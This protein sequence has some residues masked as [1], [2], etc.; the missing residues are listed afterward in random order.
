MSDDKGASSSNQGLYNDWNPTF[1]RSL[2][3][4]VPRVLHSSVLPE[5]PCIFRLCDTFLHL[6]VART[7]AAG[8]Q[9]EVDVEKPLGLTLGQKSN[10]GFLNLFS[11]LC[12]P[13]CVSFTNTRWSSPSLLCV[14][15][16]KSQPVTYGYRLT[17]HIHVIQASSQSHKPPAT[18]L[19]PGLKPVTKSCTRTPSLGMSYG[20][21]TS[22]DSRR[23]PSRPSPTPFT[24][25][26]KGE[27]SWAHQ[28][29][30]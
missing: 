10:G 15:K 30:E 5:P 21:Q 17:P 18:P 1:W 11:L 23:L 6:Q 19:R 20:P 2:K 12:E 28:S 26:C 13:L 22:S 16:K 3:I 27:Y 9:I 29:D 4:R 7:A 25:W 14:A 8:K 24:L